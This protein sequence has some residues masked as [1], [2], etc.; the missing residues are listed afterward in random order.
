MSESQERSTSDPSPIQRMLALNGRFL[1]LGSLTV[2][3]ILILSAGDIL[4]LTSGG[5]I[6]KQANYY[7]SLG[8]SLAYGFQPNFDVTSGFSDDLYADLRKVGVT[9]EV[10]YGC[11]GESTE[12]MIT[13]QCPNPELKHNTYVGSQLLAAVSFLH[14]HMGQVGLITLIIGSNDV[15]DDFDQAACQSNSNA[16][17][18]LAH[19]DTNLKQT[20]L[21]QLS[22]ALRSSMNLLATRFVMLNYYNPF[23]K[24]CPNSTAFVQTLDAHLAA[25]AAAFRIPMVDVYAAFGGN[26]EANN[27]CMYTWICTSFHDI[28]PTI[29]G[30]RI[31]SNAIENVIDV[32]STSPGLK[33]PPSIATPPALGTP[34]SS[35]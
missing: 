9:G 23:A 11:A 25:D 1:F 19:M 33:P 18:D 16:S 6:P 35:S 12:T 4:A 14:Q 30:Y 29:P 32:T 27:I 20:I 28:H 5:K 26:Q 3:L 21:P 13:G 17:S 31:I 2:V 8:D 24:D 34:A 22:D 10:D 15:F 7:L